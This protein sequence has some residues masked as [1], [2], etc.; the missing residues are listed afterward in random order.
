MS[1]LGADNWKNYLKKQFPDEEKAIDNY[2]QLVKE[3]SASSKASAIL[4]ILPLWLSQLI[5]STPLLNYISTLWYVRFTLST[6]SNDLQVLI[7]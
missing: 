5:C 6:K 7:T 1:N 4:K 2:L 3:Y